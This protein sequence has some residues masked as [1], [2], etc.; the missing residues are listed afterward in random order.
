[1]KAASA[2]HA[3][4]PHQPPRK[5]PDPRHEPGLRS[6]PPEAVGD[7][8]QQHGERRPVGAEPGGVAGEVALAVH[9]RERDRR[10]AAVVVEVVLE[11]ELIEGQLGDQ[12]DHHQPPAD[13]LVRRDR[14]QEHRQHRHQ[15]PVEGVRQDVPEQ[16]LLQLEVGEALDR[17]DEHAGRGAH[18][19]GGDQHQGQRQGLR[20]HEGPVGRAGGVDDLVGLAVALAPDE[21]AGVVDRDHDH[22]EGEGAVQGGD[23]PA[24][25]RIDVRPARFRAQEEGGAGVEEADQQQDHEGRALEHLAHLEAGALG[26]L[27][28]G[29]GQAEPRRRQ[30]SGGRLDWIG[31]LGRGAELLQPL[32][33]LALAL[34]AEGREGGAQEQEGRPAPDQPVVEQAAFDGGQG[35]VGLVGREVAGRQAIG[36][37][38][39]RLDDRGELAAV[40]LPHRRAHG[41]VQ[42]QEGRHAQ[43]GPHHRAGGRRQREEDR[44]DQEQRRQRQPEVGEGVVREPVRPQRLGVH[45]G[46]QRAHED[47]QRHE[48]ERQRD[49]REGAG[50]PSEQVVELADRGRAD[51]RAVASLVVAHD[52]VGDEG[53]GHEH[54]EDRHDQRRLGD[55]PRRVLVDVAAR[56]DLDLVDGDRA[57]HQQEEDQAGD[58]ED[59]LANLVA[60]LEG[61]DLAEHGARSGLQ[62]ARREAERVEK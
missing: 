46:H 49:R 57:E 9:V 40:Q 29:G 11:A 22:H 14:L 6:P 25:H 35:G 55:R 8:Q 23:H 62:A 58:P 28:P 2:D 52:D 54:V 7:D 61:R 17:L 53:R 38:A 30:R 15:R 32:G 20:D 36:R 39:E 19:Q 45:P 33:P 48:Q 18:Q 12:V 24:G 59:R 60:Q 3:R 51:D 44:R 43:V 50:E 42:H 27:R 4:G 31:R 13:E 10:I 41:D 34:E 56:A 5:P 37:L 47:A 16:V 21:L 1:M 26:Q